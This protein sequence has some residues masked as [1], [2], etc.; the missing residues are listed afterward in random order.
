MPAYFGLKRPL[1]PPTE[2]TPEGP[3]R[4]MRLVME[5]LD[6]LDKE[7]PIDPDRRYVTGLSMG[8]FGSFDLCVRRP[9]GFAAAVPICGGARTENAAKIAHVP[10]WIFHGGAD[11]VVPVELSRN[12]VEALEKAGASPKYTEYPGVGHDSWTKA[13]QEPELVDWLLGQ[14]RKKK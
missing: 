11:P 9:N 3:S 14:R 13:Y 1:E 7:L 12:I 6:S 2:E 8:G 5:I 10:L 4:A